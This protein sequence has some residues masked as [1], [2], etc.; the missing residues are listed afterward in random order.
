M[1][2]IS[3]IFSALLLLF[4]GFGCE[5][6]PPQPLETCG[7]LPERPRVDLIVLID[8]SG[9]MQHAANTI[10]TAA[11][12]AIDSALANCNTDLRVTWLGI[13]T[14]WVG[15]RFDSTH[16]QYITRVQ[17]GP[18]PLA[19][20]VPPLPFPSEAGAHAIEDLSRYAD[21]RRGACRAILYIS[22]EEL[23]GSFPLAD[24]ANEDQ[25]VADAIAAA[26][27]NKVA[28]FT[29]FLN[30]QLRN[31]QIMDNY[32]DLANQTGGFNQVTATRAEVTTD[33]YLDL[34]PRVICNACAGCELSQ[35][36]PNN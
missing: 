23:D 27:A 19:V 13:D 29:N 26:R 15:T 3:L 11:A 32:N 21:W 10:D 31:A 30:Y 6:C 12:I 24:F 8:A 16:R 4:A 34:M 20:D 9:S 35:L 2:T 36:M 33:L 17:G 25:A 18:V 7:I 14:T 28:V 5:D 1:R 22:D